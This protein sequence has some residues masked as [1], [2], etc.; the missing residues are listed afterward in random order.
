[1]A[2]YMPVIWVKREGKYFGKTENKTRQ[3]NHQPAGDLPVG[4]SDGKV[5]LAQ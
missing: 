1:M 5:G 3:E 4:W 2:R